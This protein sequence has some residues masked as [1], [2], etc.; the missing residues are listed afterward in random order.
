MMIP[1]GRPCGEWCMMK[2]QRGTVLFLVRHPGAPG[3]SISK[4]SADTAPELG[5]RGGRRGALHTPMHVVGSSHLP[6]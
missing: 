1:L 2:L 5:L 4:V 6:L 3:G